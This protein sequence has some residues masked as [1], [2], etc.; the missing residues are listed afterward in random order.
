[1]HIEMRIFWLAILA[2][3]V[4]NKAGIILT[5]INHSVFTALH[6]QELI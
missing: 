2:H 4:S 1:M 5:A 3:W 6:Q